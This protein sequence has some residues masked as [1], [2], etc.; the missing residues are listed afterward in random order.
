VNFER[1]CTNTAGVDQK[2]LVFSSTGF[3]AIKLIEEQQRK[4]AAWAE[5]CRN[6]TFLVCSGV[7]PV[8]MSMLLNEQRL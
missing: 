8:A 7:S 2:L 4:V 5:V 3:V 6:E 1:V